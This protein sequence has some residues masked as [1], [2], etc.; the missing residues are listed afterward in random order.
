[1]RSSNQRDNN[2][3][4]LLALELVNCGDLVR[5]TK[6]WIPGA[7][8]PHDISQESFL[9]VVSG[10]DRDLRSRNAHEPHV[11]EESNCILCLTQVLVEVG[12]WLG[13]T[14]TFEILHVDKLELVCETSICKPVP[15]SSEHVRQ[16]AKIPIPPAVEVSD[17][18][19]SS[20]LEVEVHCGCP[21]THEAGIQGLVQVT[22]LLESTVLHDRRQLVMVT[23]EHHSL[24]PADTI[25]CVLQQ[26][27][28]E[29][30]HL[31]DLC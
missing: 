27:R 26:H 28:D 20:A 19:P 18:W 4:V 23:N 22:V 3:V 12:R 10:D 29:S 15:V 31:Q 21:K 14:L 24:Q 30:L 16:I 5:L 2:E 7:S 6:D 11:H 25:L 9:T 13:F 17:T 1:M 8:R